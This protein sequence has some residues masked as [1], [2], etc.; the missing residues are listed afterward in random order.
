MHSPSLF[1]I[2]AYPRL[3][4]PRYSQPSKNNAF[5]YKRS[6]VER[7]F[8]IAKKLTKSKEMYYNNYGKLNG[9]V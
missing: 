5:L 7:N 2:K 9:R 8:I 4:L 3:L 6:K 1:L